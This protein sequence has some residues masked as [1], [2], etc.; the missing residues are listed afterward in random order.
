M[1]KR[2]DPRERVLRIL[3]ILYQYS[4]ENHGL[5]N[6][7]INTYLESYGINADRNSV[8]KDIR[9]LQKLNVDIITN[10]VGNHNE[11]VFGGRIFEV[12]ELKLLID[13]V[14]SSRFITSKKSAELINKLCKLTSKEQ[15]K[16]LQ[17]N[18]KVTHRIKS[19]NES[20][21]INTDTIQSA[22]INRHRLRFKYFSWDTDKNKRLHRDGKDYIVEPVTLVWNNTYYYLVAY[23]TAKEKIRHYRVD[24]M[25]KLRE[26]QGNISI[27]IDSSE[28]YLAT[29]NESM[30][31]MYSGEERDVTMR[32]PNHLVNVI[33]DRFGT[34]VD[35]TK[36]DDSHFQTTV[37]VV[38]SGQ[39]YGWFFGLDGDTEI[40]GPDDV[41]EEY[42]S[43]CKKKSGG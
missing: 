33:V 28:E 7:E 32:L 15:A 14:Q 18:V 24:K 12:P 39:F 6:R 11:Y 29:F 42:I 37:T 25:I 2:T 13:I 41:R 21:F 43:R 22:I 8:D 3:E 36:V 9:F 31:E 17:S 16:T 1:S 35:I 19:M 20:I 5:T 40:I 34:S 10:K 38:V 30:F 4:D 26:L 23:D 27:S